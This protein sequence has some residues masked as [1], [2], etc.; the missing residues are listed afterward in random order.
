M[1]DDFGVG[2]C[3]AGVT[4]LQLASRR[5]DNSQAAITRRLKERTGVTIVHQKFSQWIKGESSFP[6]DFAEIYTM[7]YDL[8]PDEQI[9]LALAL[10]FGQR[11]RRLLPPVGS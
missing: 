2:T 4:V 5:G 8:S 7:A 9:E 10:S 3:V 11:K 1:A 6:N